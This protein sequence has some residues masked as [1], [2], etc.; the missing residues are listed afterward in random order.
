VRSKMRVEDGGGYNCKK[1]MSSDDVVDIT[2]M[3]TN[4]NERENN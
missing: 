3:S 2:L 4:K 1:L